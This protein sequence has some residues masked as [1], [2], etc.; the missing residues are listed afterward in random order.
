M[1]GKPRLFTTA[2]V[3]SSVGRALRLHR[4]CREFES[5]ITHHSPSFELSLSRVRAV[6]SSRPRTAILLCLGLSVLRVLYVPSLSTLED[7]RGRDARFT[8]PNDHPKIATLLW[9]GRSM[10]NLTMSA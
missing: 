3:I 7:L 2:R 6:S 1:P 4:R 8:L 9:I 10:K 5:L